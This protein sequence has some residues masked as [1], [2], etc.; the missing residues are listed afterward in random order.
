MNNHLRYSLMGIML[1][2]LCPMTMAETWSLRQCIDYALENNI[3]INKNRVAQESGESELS[4]YKSQLWPSLN[5]S[6]AQNVTYRPLQDDTNVRSV[7]GEV[8][9]SSNKVVGSGSYNLSMNWTL[10]NGGI[11]RKNIR[12]Q[13]ITNKIASQTTETSEKNIQEQITQLYVQILY[14]KE[15]TKVNER[16][17]ETAKAQ[18]ERGKEMQQQGQMAKAEVVQLEAQNA[19]AEYNVVASRTQTAN[20]QRQL[21][22]LLQL[23]MDAD[24]DVEGDIPTDDAAMAI[25]PSAQEIYAEALATRPEIR[26]AELSVEQADLQYDIARRGYYPTISLSANVGDSHNSASSISVGDQLKSNLSGSAGVNIS[27]PLWDQRKTITS[28]EKAKYQITTARL[29]LEDQKKTLSSTI[30][31]YWLNATSNQQ[32]FV[33]AQAKVRSQRESY[34][35]VDEQFRNGLKNVVDVLEARDNMLSAEQDKLESKYNTILNNALLKFYGG[36]VIEL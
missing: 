36:E 26:S 14:S 23:D 12:N 7:N 10:W 8:T 17:A 2:A 25:I 33:S 32:K 4:Q 15:A 1:S 27:V 3:T 16:L 29:E 34:R 22:K 30:E 9:T 13:E 24:F 5:F 18:W 20:F 35:L 31:Q 6:T 19:A 11:N 21:K 28:K